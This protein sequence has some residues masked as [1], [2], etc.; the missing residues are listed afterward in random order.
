MARMR[1]ALADVHIVGVATTSIF[2][3][4]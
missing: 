1:A 4:G 3:A 2:S